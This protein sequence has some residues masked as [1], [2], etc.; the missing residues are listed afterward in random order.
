MT[1]EGGNLPKS[2]GGDQHCSWSTWLC[3][4]DPLLCSSDRQEAANMPV[5]HPCIKVEKLHG[6][7][8]STFP[9]E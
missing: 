6:F 7:G 3:T 2:Q 4:A 9:G 5:E 1:A 8:M